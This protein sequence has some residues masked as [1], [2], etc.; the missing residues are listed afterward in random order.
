MLHTISELKGKQHDE[1]VG[2]PQRGCRLRRDVESRIIA[3]RYEGK[4]K[5]IVG[6]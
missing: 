5:D 3:E 6:R 1:Q 2:S 4:L